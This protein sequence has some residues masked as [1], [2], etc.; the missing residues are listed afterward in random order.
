VTNFDVL[1]KAERIELLSS[2]LYAAFATHFS[3]D[4]AAH[5]LF[6][7]LR[8]EEQQHAARVRM[9][10]AQ[11]R[12]DTKLLA[13]ITGDTRGLDDVARELSAMIADVRSGSWGA[14]LAQTRRL[15]MELEDRASRAHVEGLQGLHESLRG[16]F[17]Q[18]AAQDKA[19]QEMLRG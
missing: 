8:D 3:A 6:T 19:H 17:V 12:R 1:E 4:G 7:R 11:S 2:E 13:K 9:L 14:D 10:A 18:L 15:L 5:R 16:F